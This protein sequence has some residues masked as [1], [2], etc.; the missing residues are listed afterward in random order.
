[1]T[2]FD[3]HPNLLAIF[4]GFG[5]TELLIIG[6]IALV[7]F[8]SKLPDMARSLGR[9]YRDFRRGLSD[10][11]SSID[12]SDTSSSR[13]SSS[14]ASTSSYDDYDDYDEATAPKF[15]PPPAEPQAEA[16]KPE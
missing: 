7:L 16:D 8:G 6:V 9:S 10:I 5:F 1:M 2:F 13:S 3:F 11:Q 12:A 4:S 15:E 14:Y